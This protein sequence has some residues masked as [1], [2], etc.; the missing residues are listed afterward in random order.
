MNWIEAA[1]DIDVKENE[2]LAVELEEED[3][4]LTRLDGKIYA[5]EDKCTHDSFCLSSGEIKNGKVKCPKHGARFDIKTGKAL[6][7]PAVI[8]IELYK[9][10]VENGMVYVNIEDN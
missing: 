7:L 8:P 5:F 1:K 2:I 3:I 6:E 4:I 10:K 9:V